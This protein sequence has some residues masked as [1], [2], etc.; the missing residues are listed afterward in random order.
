MADPE[1]AAF[2]AARR[3]SSAIREGNVVR[4][5]GFHEPGSNLW[6]FRAVRR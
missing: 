5:P 4:A 6:Y 1:T 3:R 2:R